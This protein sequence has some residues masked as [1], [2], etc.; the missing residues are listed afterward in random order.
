MFLIEQSFESA[1]FSFLSFDCSLAWNRCDES[2]SVLAL[3]QLWLVHWRLL[4][5]S[6]RFLLLFDSVVH[7]LGVGCM[8]YVTAVPT[9]H[10]YVLGD[11]YPDDN[12]HPTGP[13]ST[14]I[15]LGPKAVLCCA[16]SLALIPD[17]S[18][19]TTK[20]TQYMQFGES[21]W[22]QPSITIDASGQ[23][24]KQERIGVELY[25]FSL[26]ND[27]AV[28]LRVDGGVFSPSE[29][30]EVNDLPKPMPITSLI[31]QP[32]L[33]LHCPVALINSIVKANEYT[34][35]VNVNG[36]NIQ[37]G[38]T[39]HVHYNGNNTTRGSSGGALHMIGDARVIGMHISTLNEVDFEEQDSH[40]VIKQSSKRSDSEQDPYP[41]LPAK[42]KAKK[43]CDSETIGSLCGGNQGQG[44]ALIISQF[45][46]LLKYLGEANAVP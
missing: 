40:R 12:G 30:A 7:C 21:Y 25:K 3:L 34:V 39:H 1:H 11:D 28:L 23:F 44:S 38:S 5:C 15:A 35:Q 22:L 4:V 41:A 18:K 45:S 33:L 24:T 6:V 13:H 27:W 8:F 43:Q 31:L 46:K 29:Y 14:A 42:K 32:A 37:T 16:H 17:S 26:E 2:I 9:T 10:V 36:V 19:R 20:T